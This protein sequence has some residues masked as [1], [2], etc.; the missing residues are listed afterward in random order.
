MAVARVTTITASSTKGFQDA[1]QVGIERAAQTLRN[2]TGAEIV[3]Q[4][5]KIVDGKLSEYRVTMRI[6]FVLE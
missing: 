2:I 4:K 5:A 1:F 3:S 6:T